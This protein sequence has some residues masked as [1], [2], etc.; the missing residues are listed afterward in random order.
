VIVSN[1]GAQGEVIVSL[2]AAEPG[3]RVAGVCNVSQLLSFDPNGTEIIFG[4]DGIT[5]TA[6]VPIKGN[7]AGESIELVCIETGIWNV[8]SRSGTWTATA[9]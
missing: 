3:M 4:T 5:L 8:L 9:A 1:R 7:A 6:G 2:P